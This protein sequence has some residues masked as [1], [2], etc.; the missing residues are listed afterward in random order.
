MA[1]GA[2]GHPR[3][4]SII[5]FLMCLIVFDGGKPGAMSHFQTDP[6]AD[7]EVSRNGGTPIAGWF[8]RENPNLKWMMTGTPIYGTPQFVSWQ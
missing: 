2:T 8:P 4:R 1:L 7:L 3:N 6:F 5:I